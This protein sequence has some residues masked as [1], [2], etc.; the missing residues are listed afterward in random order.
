MS[1]DFHVGFYVV[2]LYQRRSGRGTYQPC[3]HG[4]CG[5][6][7]GAV[8]AQQN[9]DL[10]R[11]HVHGQFVDDELAGSEAL[12][13]RLDLYAGLFGDLI[14]IDFAL[15]P[16]RRLER[17]RRSHCIIICTASRK[18]RAVKMCV[19]E[20]NLNGKNKKKKKKTVLLVSPISGSTTADGIRCFSGKPFPCTR[21]SSGTAPCRTPTSA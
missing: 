11:M 14:G 12:A 15:E 10:I 1:D 8:V 16:E 5:G 2:A 21:R 20:N 9:G 6:L 3:Q 13:E 19:E 17:Q 18:R 7:S 4:H